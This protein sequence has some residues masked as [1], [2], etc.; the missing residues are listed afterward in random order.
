MDYRESGCGCECVCGYVWI[1]VDV[2][3]MSGIELVDDVAIVVL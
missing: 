1:R 3:V 2:D